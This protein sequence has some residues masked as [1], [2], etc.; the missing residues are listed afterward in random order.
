MSF[1][2]TPDPQLIDIW[3]RNH[4][5]LPQ[6]PATADYTARG[7]LYDYNKT[8]WVVGWTLGTNP[9]PMVDE[10][11]KHIKI[12][13]MDI[14]QFLQQ[15]FAAFQRYIPKRSGKLIDQVLNN[16]IVKLRNTANGINY[17][18]T[19]W[20]SDEHPYPI[21]NPRHN[22]QIGW[23]KPWVAKNT[24]PISVIRTTNKGMYVLL[25]DPEAQEAYADFLMQLAPQLLYQTIMSRLGGRMLTL[26]MRLQLDLTKIAE[27]SETIRWSLPLPDHI[28]I[29]GDAWGIGIR[30]GTESVT[31]RTPE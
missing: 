2:T 7:L 23:T 8:G 10:A 19:I 21:T 17:E 26:Q 3:N 11:L 15:L 31:L 24:I 27:V 13:S 29:R 14:Q 12:A 18:I 30:Y 22:G 6:L 9:A 16:S 25:Q 20:K 28:Q 4:T 1:S 5:S